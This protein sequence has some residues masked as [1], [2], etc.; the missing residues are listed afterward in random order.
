MDPRVESFIRTLA[1]CAIAAILA[2]A[3]VHGW[4]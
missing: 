2:W 3:L 4:G 1:F